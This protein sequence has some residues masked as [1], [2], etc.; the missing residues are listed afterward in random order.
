[1]LVGGAVTVRI[2]V[3]IESQ[4]AWLV[5]FTL[6]L[7]A[8]ANCCPFQLYGNRPVHMVILV[9]LISV[10]FTVRFSTAIESQPP[11]LFRVVLYVPAPLMI[12]LFQLY[13]SWVEQIDVLV[14]LVSVGLT[15]SVSDMVESQ[16]D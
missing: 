9:V 7:P 6:Y 11:W 3:A 14:V 10:V 15:I 16:P 13:G 1:V 5:R 2:S 8:A 4:F 12:W